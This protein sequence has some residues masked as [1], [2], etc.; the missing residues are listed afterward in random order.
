MNINEALE[1][2]H[3]IKWQSQKPGL[4]RTEELMG[5]MGHPE[6]D[7]RYIHIAGTNGKGSTAAMLAA[8]L[9]AAGYK[10]GLFTSPHIYRFNERMQVSGEMISDEDICSL[11]EYIKPF[12]AK[13]KE[14]PTE[15]EL[16]SAIGFEYFKRQKCDIVVLEVGLG[17]RMDSTNV[18]P[19]PEVAVLAAIGLDHTGIL[20]NTLTEIAAEKAGIIKPGC[21]AV[22]YR[23]DRSVEKVFTDKCKEVGAV[24][25][26]CEPE[27]V[28]PLSLDWD[29]QVVDYKE[30]KAMSIP[31]TGSYQIKNLSMVFKTIEILNEKGYNILSE[32]VRT[33]LAAVKWPCRFE[34][35]MKEPVFIVDGAHNPQGIEATAESL[36]AHCK[37][38]KVTF[39]I[40]VMADKDLD[41]MIPHIAGLAREFIAVTP[42]YPGRAMEA[43]LLKGHLEKYGLPVMAASSIKEGVRTALD[44]AGT[45]GIICAL[46]SLYMPV[47]IK[48]SIEDL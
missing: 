38:R 48:K 20:G 6:G 2:I 14:P 21:H 15:F 34:V 33:G 41:T 23:Q 26:L 4:S 42:D 29:V 10:T 11:V 46:G 7:C 1:Y 35:L 13:M 9:T 19:A 36:S 28:I 32:A 22:I 17:G 39:I 24:P 18:I 37:G 3:G 44:H 5:L 47:D 25:H 8:V 27:K 16:I 43:T 40:G 12:V 31:L 45:D 30:Y